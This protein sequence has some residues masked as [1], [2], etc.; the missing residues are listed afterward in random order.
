MGVKLIPARL[1]DDRLTEPH[2]RRYYTYLLQYGEDQAKGDFQIDARGSSALV[3]RDLQAQNIAA[4]GN[5]V[6]NPAFG[7]DPK[8]WMQ[9]YLKSQR[10]DSRRF[11]F[12]DDEWKQL[13]EQMIQQ[14]NQDSSLEVAKMKA[15][16]EV[17][18]LEHLAKAKEADLSVQVME[19]EKDR[20]LEM[21]LETMKREIEAMKLDGSKDVS[22][23]QIEAKLA[24]SAMKLRTQMKLAGMNSASKA[25]QVATPPTE[26]PGR[27]PAG[28]AYQK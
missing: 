27:A 11:E 1:Y 26:P 9:E 20:A 23:D 5:L 18:K 17:M 15:D 19:A 3:E 24:D 16:V 28:E 13:V 12:D 4:L 2:I 22:L 25:V 10:L 8:K 6:L 7:I 14:G 21:A